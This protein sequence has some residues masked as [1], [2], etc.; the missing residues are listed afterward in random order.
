ML[1]RV[2]SVLPLSDLDQSFFTYSIWTSQFWNPTWCS[3]AYA[4]LCCRPPPQ[5]AAESLVVPCAWIK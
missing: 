4:L 2:M 3:T 5:S 1:C